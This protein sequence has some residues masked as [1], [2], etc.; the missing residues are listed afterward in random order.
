MKEDSLNS[1]DMPI[2][3][4]PVGLAILAMVGPSFIWAAG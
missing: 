1:S 3:K 2:K 4:A